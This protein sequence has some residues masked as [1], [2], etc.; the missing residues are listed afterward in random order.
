MAEERPIEKLR[1][2]RI[3]RDLKLS[4]RFE[5]R[6][7]AETLAA[8]LASGDLVERLARKLCDYE[9][10]DPDAIFEEDAPLWTVWEDEADFIVRTLAAEAFATYAIDIETDAGIAVQ[11][12]VPEA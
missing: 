3:E 5:F 9:A 4:A 2:L 10:C 7:A 8:A 1:R 6:Q 12:I 11:R